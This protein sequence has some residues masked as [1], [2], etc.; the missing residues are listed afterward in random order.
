[1]IRISKVADYAVVLLAYMA[2]SDDEIQHSARE[3]AEA[4]HVPVPMASKILKGLAHAELLISQRGS[5][6]G[7]RLART[8]EKIKITQILSAIDGPFGITECTSEPGGC[9]LESCCDVRV[10]WGKVNTTIF[11]SL[12]H[13]SLADML[14]PIDGCRGQTLPW[15]STSN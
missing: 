9:D 4:T 7:Y 14:E 15:T 11:L 12:M 6:G 1:M 2:Q 5:K 10:N 3:L 8:P 13:I